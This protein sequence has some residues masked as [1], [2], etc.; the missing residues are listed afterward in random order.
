MTQK[1]PYLP[2]GRTLKYVGEGNIFM[3]EAKDFAL[4]HSLDSKH[5]TGAVVVRDG[6]IIGRGANGSGYHDENGCERKRKGVPTGERYDLCDGCSPKNH[7][8][9]SAIRDA[10]SHKFSTKD[11]DLYLWGHWWCCKDCWDAMI[12]A[13]IKD[14]YL[15]EEVQ[16][17]N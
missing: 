9:P 17:E 13:G 6:V 14:V 8:E 3:Q 1:L 10:V 11:A 15:M 2:E 12:L 16:E 4:S 5:R 7:A